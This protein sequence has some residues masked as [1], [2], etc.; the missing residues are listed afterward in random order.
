VQTAIIESD[1]GKVDIM[2]CNEVAGSVLSM[3]VNGI[4]PGN[5]TSQ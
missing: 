1:E 4:K 2:K 5:N 3:A